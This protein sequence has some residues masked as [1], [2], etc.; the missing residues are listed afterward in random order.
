M[1][2]S[3]SCAQL[4]TT[5]QLA[6]GLLSGNAQ[7]EAERHLETCESCLAHFRE[8]TAERFPRFRGYTILSQLGRGGFGVVYK[9]FH[10]AAGRVEALKVLSAKTPL[11]AAYFENE[12]RLVARLRHP[13][14]ATLYD[15]HLTSSPLYFA[16]EYVNGRH[17]EDYL[18]SRVVSIE[19]RLR[20]LRQVADAV[21]Y[22]HG[23]GV[24][25]RDLKPQ[26]ILIDAQGQPRI[27]DFGI[28]KRFGL[29][30]ADE[31]H[32]PPLSPGGILGTYGY[33]APE[34]LAHQPV[35]MRADIYALGVLLFHVVTGQPAKFA[36]EIGRL[37]ELLRGQRLARAADLAA[38][39]AQCVH[40]DPARRFST[41][42][43]LVEDLDRYVTG[44]PVRARGRTSLGY[45]LARLASVLLHRHSA[46]VAA[47]AAV[48]TAGACI[49]ALWSG[50]AR[51][52][53]PA[54]EGQRTALIA[55]MPST[56]E[57][58]AS[59]QFASTLPEL[60]ASDVQSWRLLYGRLMERLAAARPRV[61]AWDFFFRACRPEYDAAMVRG[62]QALGA[63]VILAA[64]ELGVDGEPDLCPAIRDAAHAYGTVLSQ[65]LDWLAT[66]VDIPLAVVRGFN[67]PILSLP[68]ATMGAYHHPASQAV[69]VMHPD[70]LSLRY[71]KSGTAAGQ[72]RWHPVADRIP[73]FASTT[74][75]ARHTLLEPNDVLA[76]GRFPLR[77]VP[78]WGERAVP[79]E[80]ALA[81]DDATLR[82][83]FADRAVLVGRMTPGLDQ[84][85]LRDG[86]HAFGCQVQ[87]AA[88]DALL[89]NL[90]VERISRGGLVARVAL[91]TLAG[92]AV[93]LLPLFARRRPGRE[94]AKAAALAVLGPVM[95]LAVAFW[96]K[97]PA[98]I[99]PLILLGSVV[100]GWGAV[101][102]VRYLSARESQL[103]PP[104]AAG[105]ASAPTAATATVLGATSDSDIVSPP[106]DR[107]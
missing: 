85:R 50:Q 69:A 59:G 44:A 26:N 14:I 3:S 64:R 73:I 105:A 36:R 81:M 6:S 41:A 96:V 34:Q 27:I 82:Q 31:S 84:Y 21:D 57:A 13:N 1:R 100:S 89:G 61:V 98:A 11:R 10:H 9:A 2:T 53:P 48:A 70:H 12:I 24:V 88:L 80:R 22:A 47:A 77:S 60:S 51:Y 68:V 92:V 35:D 45:R 37:R 101:R 104:L 95:L 62:M 25:H 20:I 71:R 54:E 5:T 8:L 78:A 102:C 90:Q 18:S 67:T 103:A 7:A 66:E 58:I 4:E 107:G 56:L 91:G 93:A 65:R 97:A 94:A 19:Q 87:A 40:A 55:V 23:E 74:A 16:M 46:P 83:H 63:P 72:S 30:R 106:S 17:L 75:T 43:E 76:L 28:A 42:R 49:A 52:F 33:I 29:E 38:I 15:A 99:E 32:A 79:L 39:I 86:T